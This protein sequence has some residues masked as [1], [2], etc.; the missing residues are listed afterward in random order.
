MKGIHR[1]Y[2][3]N[4]KRAMPIL[5]EHLP[6]NERIYRLMISE[7]SAAGDQIVTGYRL[8]EMLNWKNG[9]YKGNKTDFWATTQKKMAEYYID[10][11]IPTL[12][13]DE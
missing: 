11:V 1:S 7:L 6:D 10:N 13:D 8:H 4:V 2:M 9:I 5:E 12:K 3:W